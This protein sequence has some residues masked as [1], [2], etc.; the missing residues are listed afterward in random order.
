[1]SEIKGYWGTCAHHFRP[2]RHRA[3]RRSTPAFQSAPSA[4]GAL[5]HLTVAA[6]RAKKPEY[7][8]FAKALTLHAQTEE[9]VLYPAAILVGEYLKLKLHFVQL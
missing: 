1:M 4:I 8:A 9:L 7:E 3:L 5:K 6:K 2:T